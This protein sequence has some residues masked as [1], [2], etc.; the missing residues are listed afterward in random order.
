MNCLFAFELIHVTLI[1][2]TVCSVD[3]KAISWRRSLMKYIWID[4]IFSVPL[5]TSSMTGLDLQRPCQ[6]I[7]IL[8]FWYWNSITDCYKLTDP[9]MISDLASGMLLKEKKGYIWKIQP[10]TMAVSMATC[11]EQKQSNWMLSLELV[12]RIISQ[13]INQA[14]NTPLSTRHTAF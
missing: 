8:F 4:D 10:Q 6:V 5:V 14:Q 7:S 9:L 3:S 12:C 13:P 2:L 11:L 1:S